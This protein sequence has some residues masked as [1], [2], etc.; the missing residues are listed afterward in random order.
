MKRARTAALLLLL[1]PAAAAA[2][3][4][5]DA[6]PPADPT[7]RAELLHRRDEDQRLRGE[8]VRQMNSDEGIDPALGDSVAAMDRRNTARMKEILSKHGWPGQ[9]LV[10][11]DGSRAAW[12]L[13]QHADQDLP[14]QKRALELLGA[15]VKEGQASGRNLA[16]LTD[17]V[18]KHEGRPQVYGTQTEVVDCRRVPYPIEDPDGV[19][20]RRA[21]VGL[22]PLKEYLELRRRQLGMGPGCD[23]GGS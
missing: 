12:V 9:A 15:A 3:E 23:G 19:D 13:V 2:Q 4:P 17:R 5:S 1:A 6:Q 16:F 10:G 11:A 20:R 14:F 7:L 22:G 8:L 21:A 18:R